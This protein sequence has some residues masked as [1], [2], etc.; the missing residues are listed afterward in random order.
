MVPDTV[1]VLEIVRAI[2][3]HWGVEDI[4]HDKVYV[5]TPNTMDSIEVHI[6]YSTFV[7]METYRPNAPVPTLKELNKVQ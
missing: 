5:H 7:D 2:Q 1:R 3:A 6:P 4:F